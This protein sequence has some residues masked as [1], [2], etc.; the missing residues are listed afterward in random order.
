V[1][2]NSAGVHLHFKDMPKADEK[3]ILAQAKK[4]GHLGINVDSE[5][6]PPVLRQLSTR[7]I[8][9]KTDIWNQAQSYFTACQTKIT[10]AEAAHNIDKI[11]TNLT[12]KTLAS[13]DLDL[14]KIKASLASDHHNFEVQRDNYEKFKKKHG[15]SLLPNNADPEETRFQ[16]LILFGLLILEF[17]LNFNMIDSGG[18]VTVGEALA[19]SSGQT[20]VNII[21]CY[22]LGMVG[23]GYL[24]HA[25]DLAKK[26]ILTLAV[27]LHVYI[28]VV[29]NANMGLY[30][31]AIVENAKAGGE[32]GG[33]GELLASSFQVY[34]WDKMVNLNVT[35][36]I[37]VLMGL[38]FAVLAFLDGLKSDDTYP[39]YGRAY[40]GALK[41]KN[42]ITAQVKAINEGWN[43]CLKRF[44]TAQTEISDSASESITTWSKETNT[45]EQVWSDYKKFINELEE[46]YDGALKLYAANYNKFSTKEKAQLKASLL[47]KDEFDLKEQFDDVAV[48]HIDDKT[49]MAVEDEKNKRFAKEFAELKKE[50]AIL[51]EKTT[52]EIHEISEQYRCK[53]S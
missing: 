10:D 46:I 48:L 35:D 23:I 11:R 3:D 40:R 21:S 51:N 33:V 17:S 20:A 12:N 36:Y 24:L 13:D 43:E 2:K 4:D 5:N 45:I 28:I 47:D 30:R 32:Y 53:L 37:V 6:L 42:K 50:L 31:N 49:R 41:I 19:I 18:A 27:S 34:P 29:L 14:P 7:L 15:L 26:L 38:V 25:Q 22:L 44:N 39:G 1:S 16:K 52:K 9:Y 8:A